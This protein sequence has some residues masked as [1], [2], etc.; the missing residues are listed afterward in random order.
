MFYRG[1]VNRFT[2]RRFVLFL[3]QWNRCP[4]FSSAA[5]LLN[6]LALAHVGDA[7]DM[8]APTPHAGSMAANVQVC[9]QDS[10]HASAYTYMRFHDRMATEWPCGGAHQRWKDEGVLA[11]KTFRHKL[12]ALPLYRLLRCMTRD[13]IVWCYASAVAYALW[14]CPAAT[15]CRQRRRAPLVAS[16]HTHMRPRTFTPTFKLIL[17]SQGYA[18]AHAPTQTHAHALS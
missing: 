15:A 4:G 12:S 9:V 14:P 17:C 13:Q 11:G 5:K 7:C 2:W 8:S 3:I 16:T 6:G 1:G 10:C 18:H